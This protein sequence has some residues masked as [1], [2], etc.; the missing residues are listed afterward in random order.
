M[1]AKSTV[2]GLPVYQPGKPLEEVK[3]EFGLT[4]VIK[5]ASNENP[6]GC[7]ERVWQSLLEERENLA[8][9]PEGQAPELRAQLANHLGIEEGRF[10][11]GNGSDEIIQMI[12]RAYL[13][14]GTESVMAK[15]TFP[16][17]DTQVR[18]EG[19]RPVTVPLVDGTHDLEAMAAAVNE[20]TRIVWLCNPNNPTGTY[21]SEAALRQFLDRIP[22]QVL[23]VV[24][25]AYYEYVVAE[26]YPDTLAFAQSDPRLLVLRTFS[27]IYGL[28]SFRIGYA[29]ADPAIVMELERVREPFNANRLAQRA[30]L[31][32]LGDQ[33]F[34]QLCKQANRQCMQQI[35]SQ[36]E[37]WGLSW[38]PSQANFIMLDTGRSSDEV[39]QG[40]LQ[41]GIIVR[42][43]SALGYPTTIRVTVGRPEQ[44]RLFL[45]G[46]AACLDKPSSIV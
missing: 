24:D 4:E 34:V 16:R 12:A 44:N 13:E 41:R 22:P 8:L 23:V 31:A 39:F 9:Y 5:L 1:K 45:E 27:K 6:F 7:S 35:E 32:A 28:A 40:L 19:S 29:I 2:Q 37:Q 20:K 15:I 3:R 33:G 21:F 10:V 43:G 18:I 38:F 14:P 26:D 36:L 11:F 17:Y 30:A 46:L 25:E 42:A